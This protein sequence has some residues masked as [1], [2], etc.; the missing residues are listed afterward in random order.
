MGASTIF[1]LAGL[2]MPSIAFG[3]LRETWQIYIPLLDVLFKP[4]RLLLIVLALPTLCC[5]LYMLV[6][7]ESPKFL[8]SQG[9]EREAI[10]ILQY[11]YSRNTGNPKEDLQIV[12]LELEEDLGKREEVVEAG[13]ETKKNV[14][15]RMWSQTA[16]MFQGPHLKNTLI[17]C[18]MQF[19]MFSTS[20]GMYMFFPDILNRVATY[21]DLVN[22]TSVSS[23]L[24]NAVYSTRLDLTAL[25][26]ENLELASSSVIK[27]WCL[28]FSCSGN[29][30]NCFLCVYGLFPQV[31]SGS[32]DESAFVLSLVLELLY[33]TGFALIGT[34]I[35]SVGKKL[36][37]C[38]CFLLQ[39]L[40]GGNFSNLNFYHSFF[41]LLLQS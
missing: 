6:A 1:G 8:L 31:C 34:I 5:A 33:A 21:Q 22:S 7:P 10:E 3:I 24:C 18:S 12:K 20:N 32:L 25:D 23:T 17:A 39:Q 30:C 36:I 26:T 29:N 40:S 13:E 14:L 9:R 11:I 4:W 35:N 38:E 16:P 37:I 41:L 19:G 28:S 15:K 2:L 27:S